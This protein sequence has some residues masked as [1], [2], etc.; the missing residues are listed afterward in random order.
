MK[1]YVF[2]MLLV[3]SAFTVYSQKFQPAKKYKI[4]I[5]QIAESRPGGKIVRSFKNNVLKEGYNYLQVGNDSLLYIER[6]K[7]KIKS[8]VLTKSDGTILEKIAVS[9]GRFSFECGR[10]ACGC[11]GTTD[12]DDLLSTGLCGATICVD[13]AL[14]SGKKVCICIRN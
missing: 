8:F 3:L 12:C 5:T 13:N 11:V 14:G 7:A 9:S 4:D 1:P 2:V 10:I 6:R